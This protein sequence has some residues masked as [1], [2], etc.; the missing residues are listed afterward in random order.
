MKAIE[1]AQLI[2]VQSNVNP[3]F[4]DAVVEALMEVGEDEAAREYF[5][6]NLDNYMYG[7]ER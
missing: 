4:V 3:T 6:K 1:F 5:M 7:G 2:S